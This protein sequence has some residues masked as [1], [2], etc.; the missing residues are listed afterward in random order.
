MA[1]LALSGLNM[2]QLGGPGSGS[3]TPEFPSQCPFSRPGLG[4]VSGLQGRS[5]HILLLRTR[6]PLSTPPF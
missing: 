2:G 5:V 6:S 1:V 4:T 3:K